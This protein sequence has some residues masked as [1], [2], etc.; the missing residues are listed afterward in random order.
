MRAMPTRRAIAHSRRTPCGAALGALLKCH[1]TGGQ[2][3]RAVA[4]AGALVP[5]RLGHLP[6]LPR[7]PCGL[8]SPRGRLG[9][10]LS[11]V[12]ATLIWGPPVERWERIG[13]RQPARAPEEIP[14]G[15]CRV[16]FGRERG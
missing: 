5:E 12:R 7:L 15:P 9:P 8:G 6:E 1:L 2:A 10:D 11:V 16:A 3:R 14:S 4:W 13:Y